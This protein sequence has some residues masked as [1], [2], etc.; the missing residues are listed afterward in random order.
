ME[1]ITE[2]FYWSIKDE[3][4]FDD[5]MEVLDTLRNEGI[6]ISQV[7]SYDLDTFIVYEILRRSSYQDFKNRFFKYIF[8]E[9]TQW[10]KDIFIKKLTSNQEKKWRFI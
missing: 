10:K 5:I 8:Y 6:E 9:A 2:V 4:T 3:I 1:F 7:N